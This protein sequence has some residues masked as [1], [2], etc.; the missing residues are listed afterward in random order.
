MSE[1]EIVNIDID[2]SESLVLFDWLDKIK[3]NSEIFIDEKIFIILSNIES[4]LES[5]LDEPFRENYS[6]LVRAARSKI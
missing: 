3:P 2:R 4:S 1:N 5:I 6:E